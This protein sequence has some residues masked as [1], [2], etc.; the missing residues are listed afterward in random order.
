MSIV[1]EDKCRRPVLMECDDV[2]GAKCR[3]WMM[4]SLC[5]TAAS[6]SVSV[7]AN[8]LSLSRVDNGPSILQLV[9]YIIWP[10]LNCTSLQLSICVLFLLSDS[11]PLCCH[12]SVRTSRELGGTLRRWN[13]HRLNALQFHLDSKWHSDTQFAPNA[14]QFLSKS[15]LRPNASA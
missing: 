6:L 8:G 11:L 12:Y 1:Q 3:W 13:T 7:S 4:L 9:Q 14:V 5:S 10:Q 15:F 2:C